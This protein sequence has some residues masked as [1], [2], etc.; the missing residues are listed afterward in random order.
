MKSFV[1]KNKWLI[2]ALLLLLLETGYL[3]YQQVPVF[4]TVGEESQIDAELKVFSSVYFENIAYD[5]STGLLYYELIFKNDEESN[6]DY[7][8]HPY[9]CPIQKLID[10]KWYYVGLPKE[11]TVYYPGEWVDFCYHTDLHDERLYWY[12][13]GRTCGVLKSG[14][15][16]IIKDL[17]VYY[18]DG[19]AE[20]GMAAYEFTVE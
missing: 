12:D 4:G 18:K 11:R 6:I 10:G 3:I 2:A 19:T 17:I 20:K 5:N 1:W 9:K 14:T 13:V 15:Y 7:V 8:H 16:R